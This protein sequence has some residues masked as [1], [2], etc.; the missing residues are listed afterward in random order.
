MTPNLGLVCITTSDDV[1]FRALTRTRLML[2]DPSQRKALLRDLYVDNLRRFRQAVEFCAVHDLRLYRMISSLF[3][4]AD[5]EVGADVLDSIRPLI[6][7]EGRYALSKDIRIV[8]HPDQ[9]VVLSSDTPAVVDNSVKIL[10]FHGKILDYLA[11]P[12]TPWATIEIHGGK[13]GRADRLIE[14]IDKLGPGV[15]S[16]LALENDERAYSA[17]EIHRICLATGVPMVFDAHHHVIFG[18]LHSYDDPSVAAALAAAADTWPRR[19]W[20]LTH[21]SNGCESM[22][23]NRHSDLI[24]VMPAS[25]AHVPWIEVEAKHKERAIFKLREEWP[26]LRPP[27]T[28]P[29]S[30]Q[31]RTVSGKPSAANKSFHRAT[32][33]LPPLA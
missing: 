8:V 22:L 25:Y 29:R 23:D 31:S 17:D 26:S 30:P 2:L 4:F 12:R 9:F 13:S 24:A 14:T 27:T 33:K 16:R 28:R 5:H 3:P 19:D 1:R 32:G 7:V 20:Q 10:E 15:R 18:Q 11:Q 21:I 6:E